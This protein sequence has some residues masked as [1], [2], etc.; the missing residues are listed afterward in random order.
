M[1]KGYR[2]G[3]GAI[4]AV[5]LAAGGVVA[6]TL[7]PPGSPG[8]TMK[9][10]KDIYD[11]QDATYQLVEMYVSPQAL[12]ATTTVV[13]V[14]YYQA[15]DLVLVDSDLAALNIRQGVEVFGVTGT[16]V[17][18]AGNATAALVLAGATFSKTGEAGLTGTMAEIGQQNVTPGP[19]AKTITQGYH[20]G[21]GKVN[22]DATLLAGNIRKDVEIFGI[23]GTHEGGTLVYTNATAGVPKTGQTTSYRAGD[24][25]DLEKGV[26]LP[27]PRFTD[28]GD[29]TVTDNL[30]GL[31]WTKN[32]NLPGGTLNWSAA[33]DYCT[34]MNSVAG[35]Y[36]YTDWRLPNAKEL[37][38]LIDLG[39][40]NPA[41]PTGHPFTGVQ[42][43]IYW[44][45]STDVYDTG[46]AWTV[47]LD[48]SYVY[49]ALKE[50]TQYVWPVR[51]G[52]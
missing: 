52:Q 49:F 36:D 21:T 32:A 41:L 18:A 6:G 24:D 48:F 14:G 33:I 7:T 3:M 45:A 29:E 46:F 39:R 19:T 31:M 22:G 25:G 47:A 12:S 5:V 27:N 34:N 28:H 15:T 2:F 38:S 23:T 40:S 43:E 16:V 35:T 17:E 4:L 51:G 44:S 11:K 42:S 30:T 37:Y 10:L 20:D 1:C 13:N 50:G 8:E 26:A 9:T